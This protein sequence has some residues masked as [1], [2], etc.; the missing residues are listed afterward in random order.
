MR[1]ACIL[2]YQKLAP[3]NAKEGECSDLFLCWQVLAAVLQKDSILLECRCLF[4]VSIL[5]DNKRKIRTTNPLFTV[6]KGSCQFSD[7]EMY[8][9]SFL[10]VLVG[11][12]PRKYQPIPT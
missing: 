6:K 1:G 4:F 11:K 9:P 3:R 7:T 2:M 5:R 10:L 12:I 8:Q